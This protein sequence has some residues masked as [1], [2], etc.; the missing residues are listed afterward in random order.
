MTPSKS[1]QADLILHNG[2]ISTLDPNH[3]EA[4]NVAIK[5]GRI[6]GVDDADN[7]ERGPHTNVI[8]LKGHRE[9]TG[10]ALD[11][12]GLVGARCVER[13]GGASLGL[14]AATHHGVGGAE[15]CPKGEHGELKEE[16]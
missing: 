10:V 2:K 7:Y 3:S 14:L 4:K 6:L 15:E 8:D 13:G 11:K 1:Q 16:S 9:I 5:D 12:V